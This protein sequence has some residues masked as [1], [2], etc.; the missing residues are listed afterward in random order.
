[1]TDDDF[2]TMDPDDRFLTPRKPP[3]L[4]AIPDFLGPRHRLPTAPSPSL[5]HKISD[6]SLPSTPPQ[7]WW[8]PKKLFTRKHASIS[9][10][11]SVD[12]S[13]SSISSEEQQTDAASSPAESVHSPAMDPESLRRFLMDDAPATPDAQSSHGLE[14]TIPDEVLDEDDDDFVPVSTISEFA[15][16]TIL[17]PPPAANSYSSTSSVLQHM[18][19]NESA[20]T[21]KGIARTSPTF[22][23]KFP[24]PSGTFYQKATEPSAEAEKPVSRFSFDTD[25]AAVY[26]EANTNSP[27]ADNDIPSFYFSDAEDDDDTDCQSSPRQ[28]TARDLMDQHLL[29]TFE[30]YC[31]PRTSMDAQPK[32]APSSRDDSADTSVSI[33]SPPLLALPAIDDFVSELKSA[34]LSF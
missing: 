32:Q 17:S 7:S 28:L 25:E 24:M 10:Q 16:K 5:K 15:P 13:E 33:N 21:L 23:P 22:S 20:V 27:V 19:E 3:V 26:D 12:S 18:S 8:S 11:A 30:G 31:L 14:L 34:G 1:M 9:S 6:R 4:P 2:M 29:T